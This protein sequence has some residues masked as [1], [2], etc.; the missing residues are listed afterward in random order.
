M[1]A[2]ASGWGTDFG[3]DYRFDKSDLQRARDEYLTDNNFQRERSHMRLS[4]L[5][6]SVF[7]YATSF[8]SLSDTEEVALAGLLAW[9]DREHFSRLPRLGEVLWSL[10][11]FRSQLLD[12]MPRPLYLVNLL[13]FP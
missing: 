9:L 7:T 10:A 6:P 8:H 13:E 4:P 2:P 5:L 1:S 3:S 11:S 12:G